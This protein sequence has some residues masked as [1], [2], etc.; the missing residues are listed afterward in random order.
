LREAD[1][2]GDEELVDDATGAAESGGSHL[3][4]VSWH[5]AAHHAPLHAEQQAREHD[6]AD[7][8]VRAAEL[9]RDE[10]GE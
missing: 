4:Q 1:A 7:G 2:D 8:R 5:Q 6:Q 10:R 9:G 3:V